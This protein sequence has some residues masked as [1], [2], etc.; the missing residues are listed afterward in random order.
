MQD[1]REVQVLS[2]ARI[3]TMDTQVLFYL[4]AGLALG[5]LLLYSYRRRAL[6]REAGTVLSFS[7]GYVL[8]R[9]GIPYRLSR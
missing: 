7:G 3:R 9:R 2:F 8:R 5:M 4:W 6:E 1:M